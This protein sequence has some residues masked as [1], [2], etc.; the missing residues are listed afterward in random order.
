MEK[1]ATKVRYP[2]LK[3]HVK[4]NYKDVS[5]NE[6]VRRMLFD[7]VV[8]NLKLLERVTHLHRIVYIG[9]HSSAPELSSMIVSTV[10]SM[11]NQSNAP[12]KL[13]GFLLIYQKFFLHMVEGTE[14]K[15]NEHVGI[16]LRKYG[17]TKEL[18]NMKLLIQ[19]SHVLKRLCP[20]WMSY[21]GV[22]PKLLTPLEE[23][24][25]MEE[26]AR[27]LYICLRQTYVLISTFVKDNTE[28]G[29]RGSKNSRESDKQSMLSQKGSLSHGSF[30]G[31]IPRSSSQNSSVRE[32]RS[33]SLN[34]SNLSS[35][36]MFKDPYWQHLPEIEMLDALIRSEYTV[37]LNEFYAKYMFVP[38][39]DVYKDRVW[40]VPG[41]F[42]PFDVFERPYEC[43]TELRQHKDAKKT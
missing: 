43:A 41:D 11:E 2:K 14:D 26:T 37:S 12:D 20:E 5:V 17:T 25:N 7:K 21:S 34:R 22:P 40:P 35:L 23:D 32:S 38:Q 39:K 6:P 10:T 30:F 24:P 15:I 19:V 28:G 13:T 31:E 29:E 42:I 9:E 3:K 4:E 8:E 36:G 27:R 1:K 33:N 16:I 18:R